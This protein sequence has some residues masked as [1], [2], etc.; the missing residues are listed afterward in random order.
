MECGSRSHEAA[1]YLCGSPAV[2]CEQVNDLK[3]L[4]RAPIGMP[5]QQPPLCVWCAVA[6]FR[7][8]Q[9][10]SYIHLVGPEFL[11]IY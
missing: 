8:S 10:H 1:Y 2:D 11:S 7:R 6:P 9:Q 3:N 4:R 5:K